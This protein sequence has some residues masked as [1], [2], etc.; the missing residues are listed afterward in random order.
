MRAWALTSKRSSTR[1]GSVA[2]LPRCGCPHACGFV[3]SAAAQ[4]DLSS[5]PSLPAA[6]LPPSL[7]LIVAGWKEAATGA[8]PDGHQLQVADHLSGEGSRGPGKLDMRQ[9]PGPA[10]MGSPR[11]LWDISHFGMLSAGQYLCL[12]SAARRWM[13]A[14]ACLPPGMPLHSKSC[15][16]CVS[17]GT[18]RTLRRA[19]ASPCCASLQAQQ[20][21]AVD[22]EG[23]AVSTRNLTL[24]ASGQ[25]LAVLLSSAV[26]AFA[27]C[28]RVEL[29][30]Q[31]LPAA[32]L[33]PGPVLP[34][35]QPQFVFC[36]AGAARAVRALQR[37]SAQGR[38]AGPG[39]A[40]GVAPGCVLGMLAHALLQVWSSCRQPVP[41]W[42][43]RQL[44]KIVP[45]AA[46][47]AA[48]YIL[49]PTSDRSPPTRCAEELRR[50]ATLV[51]EA[52]AERITDGEAAVRGAL[53][54]LLSGTLFPALVS[55]H[56]KSMSAYKGWWWM[57]CGSCFWAPCSP[58]W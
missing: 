38:P 55:R 45:A 58:P 12:C 11:P 43:T 22:R 23:Q 25:G 32:G 44:P 19:R 30:G 6:H 41:V 2:G 7:L 39:A 21:V 10:A 56:G 27:C 33:V 4:P 34:L 14:A 13:P 17:G 42:R 9:G 26:E 57:H 31:M 24:K 49:P 29:D 48:S 50:H 16:Q 3:L 51:M 5:L 15:S 37:A 53:R 46:A 20:S 1:C 36:N 54:E 47:A 28:G 40:A 18:Q 52:A 8:E 35:V